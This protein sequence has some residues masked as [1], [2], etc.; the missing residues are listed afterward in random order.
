MSIVIAGQLRFFKIVG[1]WQ[2]WKINCTDYVALRKIINMHTI[3]VSS[4]VS[5]TFCY[6]IWYYTSKS[7]PDPWCLDLLFLGI[8]VILTVAVLCHHQQHYGG[9]DCQTWEWSHVSS[10]VCNIGR[11]H[12]IE[13]KKC[14]NSS[15]FLWPTCHSLLISSLLEQ[16]KSAYQ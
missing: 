10:Q 16:S 14:K 3:C 1:C 11:A 15:T 5:D 2:K 9:S 13:H 7:T 6:I 4:M 12:W 8:Y